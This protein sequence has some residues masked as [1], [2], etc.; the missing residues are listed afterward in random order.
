MARH[1]QHNTACC[2]TTNLRVIMPWNQFGKAPFLT[3]FLAW[4]SLNQRMVL[5]LLFQRC[6]ASASS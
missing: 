1:P 5:H 3:T 6:L 2:W 4:V